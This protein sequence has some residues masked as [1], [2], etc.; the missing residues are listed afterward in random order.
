MSDA[1]PNVSAKSLRDRL[2]GSVMRCWYGDGR[3]TRLL[4]PLTWLFKWVAHR[5]CRKI[6]D[7]ERWRPEVPV[8]VVG[9]ISVGG[10]GKTPVVA[11][12]VKALQHKGYRPGIASRGFGAGYRDSPL[13]VT[14]ETNPSVAGDEPVMLAQQLHVPVMVDPDR[15]SA[16][17]A[18][19]EH[20]GCN[21][22]ITDDGLQHY[23]LQRHVEIVVIDGQRMLGN[24]LCLPAGPLREPPERLQTVDQVLVN[25]RPEGDLNVPFDCFYLETGDLL[26]VGCTDHSAPEAETVHAV[27]GIGNPERFFKTLES[28]GFT[29]IPHVFPDHHGFIP[30]DIQFNDDLPVLMTGKD[31]VKCRGFAGPDTW[32]LPVQAHIQEAVLDKICQLI[33]TKGP[34]LR[35]KT[36]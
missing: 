9:N 16:A 8:V 29:V 31:A 12:L 27:A 22:I 7:S 1:S 14:P 4:L 13:L 30:A 34:Q 10:T 3:W 24:G 11:A 26:P 19:I 2:V 21:L 35:S 5:R 15:V 25:G 17:R 18:L 28:L 20:S 36:G 6:I 32:Y 33:E 23:H